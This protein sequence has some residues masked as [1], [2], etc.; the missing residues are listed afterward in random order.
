MR[1]RGPPPRLGRL[2]PLTRAMT[3]G[4]SPLLGDIAPDEFRRQAR[5]VVQWIAD[6]LE[7]PERFPVVP[8]V[9]PGQ[10]AGTIPAEPPSEPESLDVVL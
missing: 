2:T 10:I 7:H 9:V 4:S 1:R 6:Y 8:D 5:R 3:D